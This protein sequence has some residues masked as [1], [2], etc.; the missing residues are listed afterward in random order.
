MTDSEMLKYAI[1][2][3]IIDTTLM[4]QVINMQ[5]KEK[6]L[7]QHPYSIWQGKNGNW[8]TYL[9][10][11]EKGKVQKKR[12]TKEAIE[13]MVIDFYDQKENDPTVKQV[14]KEWIS[15]KL[16]YKEIEKQTYDRYDADYV[17]FIQ[18]REIENIKIKKLDELYLENFIKQT[19]KDYNLTSKGYSGLRLIL[20]GTL[21]YAKKRGLTKISPHTFF[22]D[23]ILSKNIFQHNVKDKK[24]QV[25]TEEE[26][27]KIEEFL[28]KEH[29]LIDYGVLLA[30]QIGVRVGEL[31]A[32]K[33]SDIQGNEIHIQRTEVNYKDENG[34]KI[35]AIKEFP[36]TDAGD[37]YVFLTTKSLDV[38]DKIRKLNP[39]GEYIFQRPSGHRIE[40]TAFDFH[41][42]R[43]CRKLGILTRSM[44]KIRKTY[45]TTLIDG[46]V[47]EYIIAEQMGHKDIKTTKE[48]YYYSNKSEKKRAEQLQKALVG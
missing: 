45:G 31:A 8:Y 35:K 3:G 24:E 42:R 1:E 39:C 34:V 46:D 7:A 23:L 2:N 13:Q 36:K 41:I 6:I 22:G 11:D 43:A 15:E 17:R 12:T 4:L 28:E 19:I 47:D 29:N 48:Y 9:P 27:D 40:E 20:R 33:Y 26:V 37:R 21:I 16:E 18:D 25:F 10:D 32:L 14:Y 5:K 30:F 38:L 44:H